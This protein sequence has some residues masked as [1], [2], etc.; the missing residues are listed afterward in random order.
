MNDTIYTLYITIIIENE[1]KL[2]IIISLCLIF[3]FKRIKQIAIAPNLTMRVS[4]HKKI[5]IMIMGRAGQ[6]MWLNA[7]LISLSIV[8]HE[9]C[10]KV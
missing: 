8:R 2:F 5:I 10:S 3:H 1:L 4:M 7:V 9:W 6:S